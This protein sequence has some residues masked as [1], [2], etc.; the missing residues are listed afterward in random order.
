MPDDATAP[1]P[2]DPAG[3]AHFL[4]GGGVVDW[5]N[6]LPDGGPRYAE[7]PR[8]PY[9]GAATVAE[10]WNTATAAIFV[11]IVAYWAVRIGRR[12]RDYPFVS[13]CLPV[14]LAGAVGGT[15][16]HATRT[17]RAYFLLDVIP[18]S[19]LGIAGAVYLT[20]RLGRSVGWRKVL[21]VS[22]G[23][24]VVYVAVNGVLFRAI[25]SDY[26][27]LR[28]NLSYASLAAVILTPMLAVLVRTRFR[29]GAWVGVAVGC[30]VLAWFCRLI[31]DTGLSSLPMGTH[32]L[33]HILGATTTHLMTLYFTKLEE[34]SPGRETPSATAG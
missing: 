17:Q 2:P 25:Q 13:A 3:A 7:T 32:W 22:L 14:L 16:Y 34:S 30:F 11:A 28:V 33:W 20:A 31:D 27:N 10:P 29:H 24:V 18:I 21:A 4:V 8:D 12:W 1:T 23:L 15:L 26:R 19:L 6:R 9:A 5:Q